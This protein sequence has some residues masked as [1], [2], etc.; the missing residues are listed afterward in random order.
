MK[1]SNKTSFILYFGFASFLCSVLAIFIFQG[2]SQGSDSLTQYLPESGSITPWKA[3]GEPKVFK[4]KELYNYIDGGAEIFFEYGFSQAIAQRYISGDVSITVE[5]YEMNHP[6]AAFGIYSVQRDY[7]MPALEVGDDGTAADTVVRF[8]QEHFYVIITL[9][10]P[11]DVVKQAAVKT[12]RAVS[13]KIQKS[14]PLPDLLKMLPSAHIIPRS[15]GYVSGL[16]GLNS[17]QFY[18]GESNILGING[19]TVECVF[20]QYKMQED[21]AHLLIIRYPDPAAANAALHAVRETFE[22]KYKTVTEQDIPVFS[23]RRNR[24][25]HIVADN[26]FIYIISGSDSVDL[27]KGIVSSINLPIKKLN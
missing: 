20:A 3:D 16:L 19:S 13:H 6:K 17:T 11:S 22:E 12:A 27:I 26:N 15:K 24:F 9:N 21:Q 23:D 1:Y 14:S 25:Y 2:C 4:G 5:I 7:E 8:C 10:R 18:L